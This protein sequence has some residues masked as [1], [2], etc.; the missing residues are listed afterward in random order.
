MNKSYLPITY[1]YDHML[2]KTSNKKRGILIAIEGIDGSGKTTI[3]KQLRKNLMRRNI[4][5]TVLRSSSGYTFYWKT[6]T[7]IKKLMLTDGKKLSPSIDQS[8]H[9]LEFITY[10]QYE[11]P[12]LLR[13]SDVVIADRYVLSRIALCRWD[14]KLHNSIPESIVAT[15][16]K[17]GV[18]LKPRF[19][20]YLDIPTNKSLAR[21]K[22][23]NTKPE[24]K[25]KA[26]NLKRVRS[27]IKK[28]IANNA[29][30]YNIIRIDARKP[31]AEIVAIIK[32]IVLTK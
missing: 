16:V 13:V 27:E 10:A 17:N 6:V 12:K 29:F 11:I 22:L 8:L 24:E 2:T 31:I 7:N 26:S 20:F 14:T 25:E 4:K 30:G 18:L 1:N 23:R 5:T 9:T 19:V 21:I 32:E 3:A 15:A 28:I